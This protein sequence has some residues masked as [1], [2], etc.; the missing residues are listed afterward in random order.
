MRRRDAHWRGVFCDVLGG[1]LV[2]RDVLS[3]GDCFL[4]H[5]FVLYLV[6]GL[7]RGRVLSWW[8]QVAEIVRA[9]I[10][11]S[12]SNFDSDFLPSDVSGVAGLGRVAATHTWYVGV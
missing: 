8:C 10:A 2:L 7:M 3:C 11:S 5:R 1:D 6:A 4:C 9:V 12:R